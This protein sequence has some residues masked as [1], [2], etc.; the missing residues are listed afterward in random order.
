MEKITRFNKDRNNLTNAVTRPNYRKYKNDNLDD[1]DD[2][3]VQEYLEYVRNKNSGTSNS[4]DDNFMANWNSKALSNVN[5]NKLALINQAIQS[6]LSP[7]D[8]R[9]FSFP[10]NYLTPSIPIHITNSFSITTNAKGCAWV[11]VNFGQYLTSANYV[12][13]D[14]SVVGGVSSGSAIRAS[15]V[16]VSKLNPV[17]PALPLSGSAPIDLDGIDAIPIMSEPGSSSLYNAVRAGP[18]V[19]RWDFSGRFDTSSGTI[20]TGINYS[21]VE[22]SSAPFGN[23]NTLNGLTPD[24]RYTEKKN[25]EDCPYKVTTSITNSVE[26]V[27]IPHDEDTLT[28][29]QPSKANEGIQQ[30][31]FILIS[32]AE[33]GA[34]IG[35]I[36]VSQNWEAKPNATY[37]DQMSTFIQKAPSME[38]FKEAVNEIV[39]KRMVLR[40]VKS[41]DLG[42][43]KFGNLFG[44]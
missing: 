16:F 38:I 24:L 7:S 6:I 1:D 12:N 29:R 8:Y 25:I 17:L 18:S 4:Y 22:T 32:G 28:M 37:S 39:T 31:L 35:N 42:L 20:A 26:A 5:S 9:N 10:S 44:A 2:V 21:F 3:N 15:N 34:N 40:V 41:S 11:Q 36:T 27:F 19:V 43:A 33:P 30:R 23:A 14:S 13:V